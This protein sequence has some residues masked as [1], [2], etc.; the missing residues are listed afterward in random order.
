MFETV[1]GIDPGV[2]RC[3]YGAVSERGNVLSAATC[4]VIRTPPSMPLPD[5]LAALEAE[6]EA[7]MK[8]IAPAAV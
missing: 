7:L 2:S 4:G 8:E 6:L 1:L 3:G 5:R